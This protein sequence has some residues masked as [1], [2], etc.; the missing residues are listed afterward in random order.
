ML[1]YTLSHFLN[2]TWSSCSD[3]GILWDLIQLIYN[4]EEL[5]ESMTE[6]IIQ[7]YAMYCWYPGKACPILNRNGW[8]V[9]ERRGCRG[10]DWEK[11]EEKLWLGCKTNYQLIKKFLCD[12]HKRF[13]N[14]CF[15]CK[16]TMK[17]WCIM[18]SLL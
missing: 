3:L 15:R 4:W 12:F 10:K 17:Q 7:W 6:L 13:G 14:L 1:Y 9:D 2:V 18:F 8:G 11:T 5:S 16:I